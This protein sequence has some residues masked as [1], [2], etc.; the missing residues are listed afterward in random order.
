MSC[1]A[2]SGV[3]AVA[4]IKPLFGILHGRCSGGFSGADTSH[5][6]AL[7][8]QILRPLCF[9]GHA[10]WVPDSESSATLQLYAG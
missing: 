5:A 10:R 6:S 1:E 4:V 8:H 9:F 7:L 3:A 2:G